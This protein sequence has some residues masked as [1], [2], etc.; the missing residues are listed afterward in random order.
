MPDELDVSLSESITVAQ[1]DALVARLRT[2][3]NNL[4]PA[5]Q[6]QLTKEIRCP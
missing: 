6:D 4:P 1:R 5:T 2:A 3:W